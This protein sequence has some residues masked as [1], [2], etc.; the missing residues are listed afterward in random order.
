MIKP[1]AL[2][3]SETLTLHTKGDLENILKEERRIMRKI[4]GPKITEEGYRL[5]SRTKTEMMSNLAAD[6]RKRRLKFYGHIN[7]L[8]PTRL[9]KRIMVYL[10]QIKTTTPWIKQVQNDLEKA[11][12]DDTEIQDRDTF[13]NKVDKWEVR[14]EK[15]VPRK[16]GVR[17]DDER[18]KVHS[19]RMREIWKT[20][21]A[22]Q[23]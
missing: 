5:Q 3:A 17:W 21:K 9:T 8:P 18:K 1:E 19:Q 23:K 11:Q 4:L 15:E 14:P 22:A 2:Y 6:I 12:I 10:Q 7:R 16:R 20:R 13:R